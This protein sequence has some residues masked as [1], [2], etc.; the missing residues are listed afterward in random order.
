MIHRWISLFFLFFFF[1]LS[2]SRPCPPPNVSNARSISII[3]SCQFFRHC[4]LHARHPLTFTPVNNVQLVSLYFLILF[5]LILPFALSNYKAIKFE[6]FSL[7]ST[8]FLPFVLTIKLI[9]L[10]V[11]LVSSCCW[12]ITSWSYLFLFFSLLFY[13]LLCQTKSY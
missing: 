3:S 1:A 5:P 7:P 13:L 4:V 6:L 9:K 2:R 8:F 10:S 11:Q 12:C